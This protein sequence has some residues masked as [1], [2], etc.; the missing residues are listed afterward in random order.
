MVAARSLVS[1]T[2]NALL[3][4]AL[5][6]KLM[7]RHEVGGS[8]GELEPLAVRLGLLQNSLKPRFR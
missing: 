4:K 3:E 6:A 5:R 7:R 8:L 1:P 2:S